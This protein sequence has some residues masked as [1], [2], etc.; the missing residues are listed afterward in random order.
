[1]TAPD[2]TPVRVLL[3]DDEPLARRGLRAHLAK[4]ADVSVVGECASGG[5][6]VEAIRALAPELVL[7][8]VQMPGMD[9][10]GVVDT[11]GAEAMPVVVF[12]TAF[13]AHALRAFEAQAL[14]Y[15]LKP[16]DPA[17][18]A[19]AVDRAVRRVAERRGAGGLTAAPAAPD[20]FLVR[21]GGR[22]V[23][24]PHDDVDWIEADGDYARLHVG[25]G[26]ERHLVRETMARLEATLD[27]RRFV[28]IHRSVIANVARIAELRPHANREYV[29][30][31][32]DGTRLKLS[33]S[34][35]ERLDARLGAPR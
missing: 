4:R 11:V 19:R 21:R 27:P 8:D 2:E 23:V 25:A 28:R 3:V 5:A 22:V 31:L 12:V 18:L 1:V 20:H 16:V 29:V 9:G 26:R 35:R 32:R 13:D 30:V 7:L 10:F 14:D 24:V 15:V 6:A 34:Y 33:R 17:R